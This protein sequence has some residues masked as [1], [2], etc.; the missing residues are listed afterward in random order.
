MFSAQRAPLHARAW[1]LL[2]QTARSLNEA[3]RAE[4]RDPARDQLV[5]EEQV[6]ERAQREKGPKWQ[7]RVP[8]PSRRRVV[9]F[10]V[11]LPA[12]RV[13]SVWFSALVFVL[14]VRICVCRGF[15]H[16]AGART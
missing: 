16:G 7:L 2:S 10:S 13:S 9:V 4:Q 3:H 8:D 15:V 12:A 14:R 5:A 6:L 11:E 1:R